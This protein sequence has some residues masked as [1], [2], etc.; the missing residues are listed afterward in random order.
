[1]C[2]N[3]EYEVQEIIKNC[4][5]YID[6]FGVLFFVKCVYNF[7]YKDNV[8]DKFYDCIYGYILI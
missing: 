1:M 6:V 2:W 8:V 3:Y 7:K 4:I 5:I